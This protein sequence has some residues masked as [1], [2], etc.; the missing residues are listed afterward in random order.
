MSVRNNLCSTC[1][2]E[3]FC[4]HKSIIDKFTD[5]AKHPIGIDITMDSCDYYEEEEDKR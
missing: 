5:D 2:H 1:E 3:P 4:S